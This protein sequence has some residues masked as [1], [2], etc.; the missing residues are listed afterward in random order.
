MHKH[1]VVLA[2]LGAFFILA[3][4]HSIALQFFLY[5]TYLW[6]DIPMHLWG[7]VVIALGYHAGLYALGVRGAYFHSLT[8]T[9][10]AVLL[11]GIGWEIFEIAIDVPMSEDYVSDTVLDLILDVSGGVLGYLLVGRLTRNTHTT[12]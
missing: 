11:G 8:A 3:V 2:F 9:L 4:A 7:G 5:W 10:G 12:T 6:S 1:P